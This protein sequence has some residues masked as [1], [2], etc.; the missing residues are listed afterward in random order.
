VGSRE[1][2]QVEQEHMADL[3]TSELGDSILHVY[4]KLPYPT[5]F[6]IHRPLCHLAWITPSRTGCPGLHFGRQAALISASHLDYLMSGCGTRGLAREGW[7]YEQAQAP[8]DVTSLLLGLQG[9]LN[10]GQWKFEEINLIHQGF[11]PFIK[12]LYCWKVLFLDESSE[13]HLL[14]NS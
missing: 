5:V 7:D 6:S 12:Y 8:I 3:G 10:H 11:L 4:P 2:G 14:Q 1:T 13:I 9:M